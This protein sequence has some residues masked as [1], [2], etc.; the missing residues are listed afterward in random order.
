MKTV[1]T[2]LVSFII[3][4]DNFYTYALGTSRNQNPESFSSEGRKPL[5]GT[6]FPLKFQYTKS[7]LSKVLPRAA[8]A[9]DLQTELPVKLQINLV[10]S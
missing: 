10:S 1:K 9:Q 6:F 2:S 3:K 7:L 8:L 4:K 5:L